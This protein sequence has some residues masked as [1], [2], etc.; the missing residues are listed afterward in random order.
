VQVGVSIGFIRLLAKKGVQ[1]IAVG[2][3]KN[4]V[5]SCVADLLMCVSIIATALFCHG[6]LPASFGFFTIG[7]Y[8]TYVVICIVALVF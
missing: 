3:S 1:H 7:L 2:A 6:K 8:C 4:V 5:I